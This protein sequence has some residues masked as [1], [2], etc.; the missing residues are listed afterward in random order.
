MNCLEICCLSLPS[1]K[2][3]LHGF[4]SDGTLHCDVVAFQSTLDNGVGELT[5][6]TYLHFNNTISTDKLD[7]HLEKYVTS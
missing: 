5:T 4:D 1:W 2:H 3:V 7:K 6:G